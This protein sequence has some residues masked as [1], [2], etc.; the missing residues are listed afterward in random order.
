[1]V[2]T[3]T[4]K[5]VATRFAQNPLSHAGLQPNQTSEV[6]SRAVDTRHAFSVAQ[7]TESVAARSQSTEWAREA[8]LWPQRALCPRSVP[9]A[10]PPERAGPGLKLGDG[11]YKS[12]SPVVAAPRSW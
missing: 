10:T 11:G 1:M 2:E 3:D 8:G 5:K 6:S 9:E 7:E 12:R 4:S